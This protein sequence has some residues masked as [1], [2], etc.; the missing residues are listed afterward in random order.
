M[1]IDLVACNIFCNRLC[2]GIQTCLELLC[3]LVCVLISGCIRC[4]RSLCSCRR[5]LGLLSKLDLNCFCLLLDLLFISFPSGFILCIWECIWDRWWKIIR[6]GGRLWFF[7]LLWFCSRRWLFQLSRYCQKQ[8]R[9]H[10]WGRFY[11]FNWRSWTSFSFDWTSSYFPGWGWRSLFYFGFFRLCILSKFRE[12]YF[13]CSLSLHFWL[14]LAVWIWFCFGFRKGPNFSLYSGF[15]CRKL[16]VICK[17]TR[18][19]LSHAGNFQG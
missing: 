11:R 3:C 18:E 16:V 13:W 19:N 9:C 15:Y 5:R 7:H 1:E 12:F 14:F 17:E 6:K 4:F 10:F 8:K 2:C